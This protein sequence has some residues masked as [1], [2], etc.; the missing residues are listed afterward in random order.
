MASGQGD[1]LLIMMGVKLAS[2]EH[3]AA[4]QVYGYTYTAN[5]SGVIHW[6]CAVHAKSAG[7]LLLGFI[8]QLFAFSTSPIVCYLLFVVSRQESSS[9]SSSC[10]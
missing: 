1:R 6:G 5:S 10:I 2:Q 7:F 3:N 8:R 4:R 9:S